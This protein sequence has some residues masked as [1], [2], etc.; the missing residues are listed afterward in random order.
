MYPRT[1][2]MKAFQAA[3]K[4]GFG[5]K[6]SFRPDPHCL[7]AACHSFAALLT[8]S[9]P[10]VLSWTVGLPPCPST[11]PIRN[12]NKAVSGVKNVSGPPWITCRKAEPPGHVYLLC[13][14]L[15]SSPLHSSLFATRD[16][17]RAVFPPLPAPLDNV[18]RLSERNRSGEVI[19]VGDS[20]VSNSRELSRTVVSCCSWVGMG[21]SGSQTRAIFFFNLSRQVVCKI[22]SFSFSRLRAG[23]GSSGIQVVCG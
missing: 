15:L 4:E 11:R 12:S 22:G 8:V 20:G 10:L 2:V 7:A 18:S 17:L 9:L 19:I 14:S 1:D 23:M 13:S 16:A 21:S 5:K 3:R 6:S